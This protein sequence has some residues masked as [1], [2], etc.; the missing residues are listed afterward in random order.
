MSGRRHVVLTAIALRH[1]SRTALRLVETKVRMRSIDPAALERYLDAG[2]WQ[3]KAGGYAIQGQRPPSS[4][5]WRGRSRPLSAC[6]CQN[7]RHAGRDRHPS[8]N[9]GRRPMKG[10]QVVLGHLFGLE[11]AALMQDG[12]L[13][14]LLVASDPLTA[15]APGAICRAST[16]RFMKGRRRFPTR[17]GW[18][19]GLSARRACPRASRC[20]QVAGGRRRQGRAPVHAPA[21]S[22]PSRAG[23]AGRAGGQRVAQHPRRGSP[24]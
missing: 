9:Q 17:A 13:I 22:R 7:R 6:L 15:L 8:Q 24:G 2:D 4:R 19:D 21:V 5:G 23:H 12:Q 1:G 10:R 3:G 18:P 16:D 14:D 11:A 20:W